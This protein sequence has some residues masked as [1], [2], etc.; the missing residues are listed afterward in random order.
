M[1]RNIQHGTIFQTVVGI[2]LA[3]ASIAVAAP[4]GAI[5]SRI[6]KAPAP[7]TTAPPS[8]NVERAATLPPR[9]ILRRAPDVLRS[10]YQS[11]EQTLGAAGFRAK[12]VYLTH[13]PMAAEG[14]VVA[15]DPAPGEVVDG[16]EI[17]L[18]VPRPAAL[19]GEGELSHQD[20]ERR[21][22]FDLDVGR[23]QKMT[24][25]ADVLVQWRD[26]ERRVDTQENKAYLEG[27]GYYL[28]LTDGAVFIDYKFGEALYAPGREAEEV[29]GL[30]GYASCRPVEGGRM[31]PTT[32]RELYIGEKGPAQ[33]SVCVRT[34]DGN[35]ALLSFD[36]PWA[37]DLSSY[38][39]ASVRFRYALFPKQNATARSL[40]KE[41]LKPPPPLLGQSND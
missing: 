1:Q 10:S 14:I 4:P 31:K 5:D 25:G 26:F 34:S 16:D 19:V 12:L 23:F 38:G 7:V 24:Y 11:A 20:F 39:K 6:F 27:R 21:E 8:E 33:K 9:A 13:D 40:R 41:R 37:D 17:A 2:S 32:T 29:G 22:G 35:I 36:L 3:A 28:K 15:T 30:I 18:H